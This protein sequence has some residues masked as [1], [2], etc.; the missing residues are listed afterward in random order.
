MPD[1][2]IKVILSLVVSI[3][4]PI[5]QKLMPWVPQPVWDAIKEILKNVHLVEDPHTLAEQFHKSTKEC[6]GV[7]CPLKPLKDA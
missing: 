3:G 6:I 7:A 1:W 2:L 5:A 4:L